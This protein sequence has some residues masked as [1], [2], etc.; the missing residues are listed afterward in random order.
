M[1][2]MVK[3]DIRQVSIGQA[4]ENTVKPRSCIGP[5]KFRLGIEVD[6]VFVSKCL[7]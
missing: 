6:K 4:I 7:K 3:K 1:E 2:S 5:L